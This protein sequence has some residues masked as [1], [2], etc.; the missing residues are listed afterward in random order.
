[1]EL[2]YGAYVNIVTLIIYFTYLCLAT[3][4]SIRQGLGHNFPWICMIVLSLCRLTQVCTFTGL[5][6]FRGAN[7]N[8]WHWI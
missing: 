1:M 2:R 6:S 7:L 8:R 5:M 3:Y 4:L